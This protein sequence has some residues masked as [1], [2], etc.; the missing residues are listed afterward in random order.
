[1]EN[2]QIK[3]L[4]V[5][6][7]DSIVVKFTD[8]MGANQYIFVDSGIVGAYQTSLKKELIKLK[9]NRKNNSDKLL[10][11]SE[12][13]TKEY[14]L[15]QLINNNTNFQIKTYKKRYKEKGK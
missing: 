9:E 7:G 3:M 13:N 5:F 14:K 4:P 8:N 6:K 11:Y 12:T 15:T 1:M 2:L 10:E